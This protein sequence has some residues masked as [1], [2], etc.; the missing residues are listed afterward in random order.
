[1]YRSLLS[2]VLSFTGKS[3]GNTDVKCHSD[4]NTNLG[5]TSMSARKNMGV[6]GRACWQKR[7]KIEYSVGTGSYPEKDN[8]P[9]VH[10]R[11]PEPLGKL[12]H[13][14]FIARFDIVVIQAKTTTLTMPR[15]PPGQFP[16]VLTLG[17]IHCSNNGECS[18][19]PIHAKTLLTIFWDSYC[20]IK[21]F[22]QVKNIAYHPS[23]ASFQL[24]NAV[25]LFSGPFQCQKLQ[26]LL[27]YNHEEGLCSNE[28]PS[29][30]D[31]MVS[32]WDTGRSEQRVGFSKEG[33][34]VS[35]TINITH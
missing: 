2:S 19:L 1:M 28:W 5:W 14:L 15:L 25:L 30:E 3:A 29:A 31:R 33:Q 10:E 9:P 13:V 34:T 32:L 16:Q 18:L 26:P 17:H 21:T 35:L 7:F 20:W 6:L 11:S 23:Y 22:F 24:M 27:Q 4:L 12:T 8:F